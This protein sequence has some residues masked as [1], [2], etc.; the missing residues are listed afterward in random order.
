MRKWTV[1]FATVVLAVL[2]ALF[3]FQRLQPV[4]RP[5]VNAVSNHTHQQQAIHD[6]AARAMHA[7]D[8]AIQEYYS[9]R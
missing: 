2:A 4:Q 9:N 7:V 6:D 8:I 1:N 5:D 3:V